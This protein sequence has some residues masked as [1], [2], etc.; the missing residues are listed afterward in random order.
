MPRFVPQSLLFL[1]KMRDACKTSFSFL[2]P[3]STL[4]LTSHTHEHHHTLPSKDSHVTL[5]RFKSCTQT[6]LHL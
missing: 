2:L 3:V 1:T 6:H 4:A 5:D